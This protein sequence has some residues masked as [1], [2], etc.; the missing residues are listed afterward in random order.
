VIITSLIGW[1]VLPNV[2][3]FDQETALADKI[4]Q[5]ALPQRE[6]TRILVRME[7]MIQNIDYES[8]GISF[9]THQKSAAVLK[10]AH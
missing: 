7:L 8:F 5:T 2:L 3:E 4:W 9:N 10:G 6:R 1:S